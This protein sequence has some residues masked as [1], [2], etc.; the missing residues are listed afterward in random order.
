MIWNTKSKEI[1]DLLNRMDRLEIELTKKDLVI[2]D[3]QK[4]LS[5]SAPFEE[6]VL[7]LELWQKKLSEL[8]T[9]KTPT[10]RE[11]LSPFGKRMFGGKSKGFNQAL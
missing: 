1:R 4:R 6:R 7:T 3:L 10:G 8:I 2:M 9:T 5:N 11:T